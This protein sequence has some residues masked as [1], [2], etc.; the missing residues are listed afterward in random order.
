MGGMDDYLAM[1]KKNIYSRLYE[2]HYKMK[3]A[4]ITNVIE[5]RKRK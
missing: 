3:F 1:I 4:E 2:K 5:M